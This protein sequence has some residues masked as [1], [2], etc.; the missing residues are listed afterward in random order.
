MSAPP[1]SRNCPAAPN[2]LGRDRWWALLP[3]I[4]ILLAS[5]AGLAPHPQTGPAHPLDDL[6]PAEITAATKAVRESG[7]F[8]DRARFPVVMAKE[9]EKGKLNGPAATGRQASLAVYEPRA[10]ALWEVTVDLPSGWIAEAL[11]VP[12]AQPPILLDEY[13]DLERIVKA[14]DRFKAAMARRGITNLEDVAVDGWA[15]GV[16]SAAERGAKVRLMRGVPYFKGGGIVNYYAR[17]IEGVVAT[18]DMSAG[19]V[20]ELVD[21]GIVPIAAGAQEL[22]E[23]SNQPSRRGLKPLV[24]GMPEACRSRSRVRRSTGRTGAS[25]TACSR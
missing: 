16:L 1:G 25:T 4:G 9:P 13:E 18:V 2:R 22:S 14:D 3:V 23:K 11:P 19:A 5:C 10:G 17:P 8:T 12:G 24:S 7:R 21:A 20:I 6:S 15:A